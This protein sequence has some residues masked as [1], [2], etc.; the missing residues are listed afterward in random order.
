MKTWGSRGIAP[1]FLTSALDGGEWSASLP[2]RLT[3][4]EGALDTH[5]IGGW[6][7][8]RAGLDAMGN[9]SPAF[10]PVARIYT[11]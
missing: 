6:M 1:P 10:Q 8:P 5:R 4:G 3:A 7:G 11:D 2:C 9:R